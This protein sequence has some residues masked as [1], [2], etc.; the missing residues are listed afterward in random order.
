[1]NFFVVDFYET[2][3]D[4]VSFAVIA[5]GEGYDL[6]ESAWNDAFVFV[7]VV[8]SHH[9]VGLSATCL[10]VGEDGSIVSIEHTIDK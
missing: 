3:T 1:M 7:T 2:A 6:T 9:R 8:V 4:K 5:F 10:T